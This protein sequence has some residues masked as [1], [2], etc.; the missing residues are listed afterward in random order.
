MEISPVLTPS[1]ALAAT[2]LAAKP[3]AS[4]IAAL[5]AGLAAGDE[6]AFREFHTLYA[7]RLL[8]YHLVLARGDEPAAQEALQETFL[9]VVRHARV[10][11]EE[12]A[13]WCWLT[14]LA[15]SAACDGGRTR[16]RYWRLLVRYARSL[17]F[18][19]ADAEPEDADGRLHQYLLDSLSDLDPLDRSLVEGKYLRRASVR[20]LAAEAGLTCK[21]VESRLLRA[22]RDLR[23]AALRRMRHEN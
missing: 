7:S 20:E 3:A 9:R 12:S 22:R 1:S 4:G 10:F 19:H 5:T 15:R 2:D 16:Q 13:F 11:D 17:M 18:R 23:Q 6:Q 8:R 21:A 14:V